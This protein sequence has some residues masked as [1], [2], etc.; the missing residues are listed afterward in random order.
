MFSAFL[1]TSMLSVFRTPGWRPTTSFC[2]NMIELMCEGSDWVNRNES[3][4]FE[5]VQNVSGRKNGYGDDKVD[6]CLYLI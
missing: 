4:M 2:T 3:F 1:S 6:Y 5:K